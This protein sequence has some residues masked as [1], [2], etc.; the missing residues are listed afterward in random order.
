MQIYASEAA[1]VVEDLGQGVQRA[2]VCTIFWQGALCNKA[3]AN[4]IQR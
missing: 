3:G 2:G 1:F 4:K